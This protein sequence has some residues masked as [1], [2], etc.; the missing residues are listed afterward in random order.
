MEPY[1]L[2]RITRDLEISKSSASV[3]ARLPE[4]LVAALARFLIPIEVGY[5]E[6]VSWLLMRGET[7]NAS[8]IV[9]PPHYS[10]SERWLVLAIHHDGS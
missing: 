1:S 2:D 8:E 5:W 6:G 4:H 9:A 10:P 7:G 3:A